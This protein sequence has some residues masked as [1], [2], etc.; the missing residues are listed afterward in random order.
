VKRTTPTFGGPTQPSGEWELF[1]GL[2]ERANLVR[3]FF[4]SQR[5][6]EEKLLLTH[7]LARLRR[8]Y[9]V[10]FC[11]GALRVSE[12]NLIEVGIP[13]AGVS[14]LPHNFALRA[15]ESVSNSRAPVT[16][17]DAGVGYGFRN[18]VVAPLRAP[19]DHAFGF[20]MLG[21]SRARSYSAV[22]LFVFQALAGE[23]SWVLRDLAARKHHQQKLSAMSHDV[24]DDLQTIIGHAELIQQKAGEEH[25]S[26]IDGHFHRIELAARR[27]G[28]RMNVLSGFSHPGEAEPRPA[29]ETGADITSAVAQSVA[30]CQQAAK[31]RGIDVEVVYA[32]DSPNDEV[33][34]PPAVKRLLSAL[35]DNA[36]LATRNE[37]VRLTIGRE[38]GDLQLSVKGMGSNRVADKLKSMFE[39]AARLEGTRDENGEALVRVRKYLDK[40]GGDVYLKSHPGEAAEFVVRLPIASG[41][42]AGRPR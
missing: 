9:G 40:A 37:R 2:W 5:V 31:E 23:L 4:W 34:V 7:F 28:D 29:E 27:I 10:D 19:T 6:D 13:E 12:H 33:V 25:K 39:A 38:K 15:L 20:L 17:N 41:A 14:Q 24:N 42:Q 26:E 35:V 8:F 1:L 30:S 3:S 22:E 16:W 32:P 11:F 36:A 18:T 21:H